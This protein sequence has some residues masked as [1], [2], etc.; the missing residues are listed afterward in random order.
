MPQTSPTGDYRRSQ[1]RHYNVYRQKCQKKSLLSIQ[2]TEKGVDRQDRKL[3]DNNQPNITEISTVPLRPGCQVCIPTWN[4]ICHFMVIISYQ[5]SGYHRILHL[6]YGGSAMH[7]GCI[8]GPSLQAY[9]WK[10]WIEV[11]P[12]VPIAILVPFQHTVLRLHLRWKRKLL[13]VK[14]ITSR[15]GFSLAVQ[16]GSPAVGIHSIMQ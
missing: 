9:K 4:I 10:K 5:E 7:R 12:S 16:G 13:E 2:K 11:G 6:V 1:T 14:S 3:V 8:F 15:L